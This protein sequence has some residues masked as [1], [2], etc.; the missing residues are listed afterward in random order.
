MDVKDV[1]T[2]D[3]SAAAG[4]EKQFTQF[5]G[6]DDKGNPIVM[7][8]TPEPKSEESAASAASAKETQ[9]ESDKDESAAESET[10]TSQEKKDRKPGEKLSAG[11]ELAKLRKELREAKDRLK[12][13]ERSR[14]PEP[15]P[16]ASAKS[17]AKAEQPETYAEW[18]KTFKPKEWVEQ[19]AK[20]NTD[21]SYEDA[22]A[23]LGDYQSELRLQFQQL[24]QA[25]EAGMKRGQEQLRKA[26]DKYPDAEAQIKETAKTV[27]SSKDF[28]PII[29]ALI[30]D[31][32]VMGHLL[33]TLSDA[34]TF[35][36]FLDT[37]K[38]NPGK[39]IRVLRDM[40]IEIEK[41][42]AKPAES[43]PEKKET[44]EKDDETPAQPK[45]RAPKPPSEVGGRGTGSDDPAVAAARS[46]DF[47]SFDAAMNARMRARA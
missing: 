16:A 41:A 20:E 9:S 6:W 12:E 28:P 4:A 2:A 35:E 26:L 13:R 33:Y 24:E 39:A 19:W 29:R 5:D 32:E 25:R 34:K 3:P 36:N 27:M 44:K 37:V 17:E 8:K 38:S 47:R 14:E 18:R 40:E 43:K 21:A 23:A 7:K 10:A 22:V 46:G 15:K 42:I 30:N 1:K 31:S 11:E 45:P